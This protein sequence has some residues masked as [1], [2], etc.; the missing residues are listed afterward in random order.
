MQ[1]S[2]WSTRVW[3][4]GS[5][6]YMHE[7]PVQYDSISIILSDTISITIHMNR[8]SIHINNTICLI[9]DQKSLY[10]HKFHKIKL[11]I[12]LTKILET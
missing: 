10:L 5:N 9:L 4:W 8:Y 11:G 3:P 12:L 7:H 1:L 2:M 6:Y